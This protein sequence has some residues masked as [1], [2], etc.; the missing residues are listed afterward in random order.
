MP[1]CLVALGSNVGDRH[2]IL[3]GAV[4]RLQRLAEPKTLRVSSRQETL[5]LGGPDQQD[6]FV[7]AAAT[8]FSELEPSD[9]LTG[10]QRIEDRFERRR[11][12][13]WAERSL[14]LDLLLYG[15]EVIRTPHLRVPHPRMTYRRFVLQPA[16]E[17]AGHWVHPE[18][19]MRLD[20]LWTLLDSHEGDLDVHGDRD[21]SIRKLIAAERPEIPFNAC[22]YRRLTID[23]RPSPWPLPPCGPRL[24]LA[25]CPREH[26]RDEILAALECVWPSEPA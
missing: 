19:R 15:D 4:E 22:A 16:R 12:E 13:R 23:A 10:L 26:W 21:R 14:D 18:C 25:D 8:F 17:I 9:L 2:A 11:G 7:N 1:R 5:P 6:A 24:A 20:R 3:D